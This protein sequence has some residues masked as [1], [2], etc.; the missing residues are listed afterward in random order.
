MKRNLELR[1]YCTI[2]VLSAACAGGQITVSPFEPRSGTAYPYDY[3]HS[4]NQPQAP[5]SKYIPIGTSDLTYTDWG[6]SCIVTGGPGLVFGGNSKFG[7]DGMQHTC[8]RQDTSWVRIDSS[9]RAAN[10]L[11]AYHAQAWALRERLKDVLARARYVYL[12][13]RPANN[14]TAFLAD[15]VNPEVTDVAAGL[16][17]LADDLRATTGLAAYHDGQ[18]DWAA[19]R[20]D[21]AEGRLAS[22]GTDVTAAEL[23]L[24][25]EIQIDIEI[26]S[27]ALDAEPPARTLSMIAWDSVTG[28]FVIFGGDHCDYLTNDLWLFDPAGPQWI[29]RHCA[30]SPLPRADHW[31]LSGD[32]GRVFLKGGYSYRPGSSEYIHVGPAEWTYDVSA[33]A[34]INTSGAPAVSSDTRVY[35]IGAY[36]PEHF[37]GG[38]KPV[39][40][41]NELLLSGI[42]ANTW[43][44]M[45]PPFRSAENRDWGTVAYDPGRDMVYIYCGG[46]SAYAGT[47][48]LHYHLASNRYEQPVPPDLPL[49]MQHS[50]GHSATGWSLN[51]RPWMSNHTWNSYEYH[52]GLG[53]MLLVGRE[54]NCCG[55]ILDKYCYVYDPDRGEWEGRYYIPSM[56]ND[57]QGGTQLCYTSL[58]MINWNGYAEIWLLNDTTM[59]WRQLGVTGRIPGPAVDFSGIVHDPRRNRAL[60]FSCEGYNVPFNGVVHALDLSTLAMSDL[61]PANAAAVSDI[62][63]N[64]LREIAYLP[65]EDLFLFAGKVSTDPGA[66]YLVY[67]P[68]ANLWMS[69]A[70]AGVCDY[71]VSSGLVYDSKRGL[72]WHLNS[73]YSDNG[74]NSNVRVVKIDTASLELTPAG[75][76]NAAEVAAE[77]RE[78]GLS[79]SPNPFASAVVL[80]VAG[81]IISLRIYDLSGKLVADVTPALHHGRA[82]W[83]TAGFPAGVYMVRAQAGTRA[84]TKKIVLAGR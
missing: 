4:T 60:L 28:V 1:A 5:G 54:W 48:V 55:A 78:S 3:E 31:L 49:G 22:L 68:V 63:Y 57:R 52:P 58:G 74:G 25:R 40:S 32:S 64:C 79:A 82:V 70:I 8:V 24:L 12:E 9:L 36:K 72:V 16:G 75:G 27:E 33:N 37:L 46:H 81:T 56:Y 26:A 43:I 62:T 66:G 69:A 84:L 39:S 41:A 7:D 59:S 77:K 2:I 29:Q 44:N 17:Q 42:A 51:Q 50:S 15:S 73:G 47:D 18:A 30:A 61:T 45:D 23:S 35:R 20:L 6:W 67:D 21:S 10:P 71:G 38:A 76:G 14:E 34:W 65:E 53:K 83:N 11:Q 80:S 13:G 19:A